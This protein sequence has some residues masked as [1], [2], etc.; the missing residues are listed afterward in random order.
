MISDAKLS[1]FL[2]IKQQIADLEKELKPLKSEIE[3]HG[4]FE[5][6]SFKVEIVEV[7]TNRV[8]DANTLLEKLGPVKVT[9]LELIKTSTYNKVNVKRIEKKAA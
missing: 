6:K 8:V 2:A 1:S 3:A 9:E 5:S 7:E 4:S